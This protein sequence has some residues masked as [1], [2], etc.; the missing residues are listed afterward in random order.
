MWHAMSAGSPAEG[1]LHAH[2]ALGWPM[3]LQKSLQWNASSQGEQLA[4]AW[5][6]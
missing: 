4:Q 2:T 6:P 3:G 5:F 1:T